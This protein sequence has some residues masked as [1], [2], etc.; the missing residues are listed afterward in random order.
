VR[1]QPQS[2][3]LAFRD[4]TLERAFQEDTS[5]KTQRSY[6]TLWV[7]TA[8]AFAFPAFLDPYTAGPV[9]LR[10]VLFL[11]LAIAWPILLGVAI[12]GWTSPARFARVRRLGTAI[13]CATTLWWPMALVLY[14]PDPVRLA[15]P[16]GPMSMA[17]IVIAMATWCGIVGAG[18]L[19]PLATIGGHL[20]LLALAARRLPPQES[21][22]LGFWWIWACVIGLLVAWEIEQAKRREFLATRALDVERARSEQLLQNVLPAAIAERLKG[23]RER[24]ADHFD[25]ATVLFGDIVGFTGLSEELTPHELVAALDD[26]FSAFDDIADRHGLEKIKTIG[27][28]YMVVGGVPEPRADHADAVATMALEMRDVLAAK[29]FAGGRTLRMRIGIHTGP[30]VAGVIGKKKFI[31]DLWGDTV[32][33]ASR[34]ESHGIEGAVQVTE[35]AAKI[36]RARFELTERGVVQVK[37]K[38]EMRTWLLER[39]KGQPA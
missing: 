35:E 9:N 26:V 10:T 14:V 22:S 32:N 27:D 37:G 17:I 2:L 18:F 4:A 6:R 1:E 21:P 38:G 28:A 7:L 33:T 36:L 23:A 39:R 15:E 11:R 8:I 3:S 16:S 24:I 12:A 31:Y 29:R 13:G 34:M 20:V 19:V 5:K 25:H 30:V